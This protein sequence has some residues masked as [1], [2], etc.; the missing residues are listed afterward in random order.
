MAIFYKIIPVFTII[1][2]VAFPTLV[3]AEKTK[4]L[5]VEATRYEISFLNS[6]QHTLRVA[7]KDRG[8]RKVEHFTLNPGEIKTF[9]GSFNKEKLQ[10]L[11]V[12]CTYDFETFR[13]DLLRFHN[14]ILLANSQK[15]SE[16]EGAEWF[17]FVKSFAN[18][19]NVKDYISDYDFSQITIDEKTAEDL[20][21][22]I[23]DKVARDVILF[24]NLEDE[25]FGGHSPTTA[26]AAV[27]AV[28]ELA[29]H[30]S[31]FNYVNQVKYLKKMMELLSDKD[32]VQSNRD[33]VYNM[34]DGLDLR[35]TTSDYFVSFTPIIFTQSLNNSWRAPNEVSIDAEKILSEGWFNNTLSIHLGKAITTE[36]RL[37]SKYLHARLYAS[38]L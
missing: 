28:L 5:S 8:T 12:F 29:H 30:A 27:A 10:D 1:V 37:G 36:R 38:F 14:K 4:L 17:K 21:F 26:K 7:L 11:E 32:F 15:R 25:N 18:I 34:A 33:L 3:Q 31:D 16:L 9:K 2:L 35:T 24:A 20:S 22:D 19:Q 13:S 23:S 6:F